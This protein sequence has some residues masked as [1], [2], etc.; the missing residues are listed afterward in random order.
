MKIVF[1]IFFFSFLQS[2]ISNDT[3][4]RRQSLI[5][6]EVILSEGKRFAFGFFSLGVSKLR[7]VGIWYAQISEQTVVWVANRDHPVN[8]TSGLIK[9]SSRGNLCV[10]ASANGTEPLWS[11]NVSDSISEPTLVARLSNTGNL[12]LIDSAT[13]RIYWESFDHPTDTFLPF[14]KLGFTRKDGLDRV[15]TS[16]RS[17]SDP[18]SGNRTF[19]MDR[20][21]FPELI[22]HKGTTQWWR[23]GPWTGLR[24]SGVAEMNRGYIFNNSFVNSQ[25]E[26]S[27]TYGVTDASV[28]TRMKVNERGTLQRF[29]WIAKD[30]RWNEF[31][32]VPKEE[33]DYYAHCGVNGF[34][35]P[36]SSETFEC[37]CLPGF[38]PKISRH[39]FLRDYTGGCTRKNETSL[40]RGEDGF[41]K[42]TH[43][44]IPDTQNVSVVM[45][46]TLKDC[47]QRCLRNCSCVAYAS[48][49]HDG[50]GGETGCLTW[51]GDMLDTRTYLNSG[52]DFYIRADKEELA[53]WDTSGS[54]RKTRVVAV[55]ISLCA[56][57]MLLMIIVFCFVRKRRKSSM[58]RRSSTT[59]S[60]VSIDFENSLKFEDDKTGNWELPFFDL[61]T[62]AAATD[63]FS[64]HNKLGA[65]GFGPVYKGV[66][67]NG[68]EIAVKRLSKNSGQGMEE[69]KNEVKL[70]S[71][72]QHRN[73]VRIL[74]CCVESEEKMLVY[75]YLPNKSLDCFIFDE[76][77]RAVLDWPIRM[78]IIRGI[79]R[80]TMYLH[81]DSRLRII[82]RDLKASNI[83]L[84][85]EMVPKISDF[86][87]ARIFG[88]NQIEGC[89]NRV[90]G[91]IGYMS[92]E[93]AME[94]HFSVKSD[95]YSFGVLMLEIISGKKNSS[96][97]KESSNLVGHIW[98]LWEKSE[99]KDIIDNLMDQETYN[100]GEAV[101]C[102]HIGLLCVQENASDRPDMSSVLIML[103]Q[104]AT[105]LP[106]PK[107]PAFTSV[108]RRDRENVA[109]LI[110]EPGIS[111]NDVTFTD[112]QG[113]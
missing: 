84:D 47:K 94:G 107:L 77:Q 41:V 60:M 14:M 112:V 2:C 5:D 105:D 70:I 8:G 31:W 49:Y 82:H 53:R 3:I 109:L 101:K 9:F 83:L 89:T 16:W 90:V 46:L 7:Y 39:W 72:L 86:G 104:N 98:D 28:I 45:N 64:P 10:Y 63:N 33:C 97:H 75:E 69:F 55:I 26:V 91:T 51:H 56:A 52:Q 23:T 22:L 74:G 62:I 110:A 76:E 59:F 48:A 87:M 32:S 99:A 71:K 88:G 95:V 65:G 85:N 37:T 61:N 50:G 18:G 40:C 58:L 29:T 20:R 17:P 108:I 78:K 57:V 44:K 81:Q 25:D 4:M 12:V 103:G 38:Q 6:G 93:Y 111:V 27:F 54:S 11:T 24:W 113:R 21:G 34:C 19:G 79:A 13:G 80:G 15:L 102:I 66:L 92:P 1:V 67:Q 30:K 42:L 100:E 96:F 106:N 36:T 35:D 73:L 68:M 43:A